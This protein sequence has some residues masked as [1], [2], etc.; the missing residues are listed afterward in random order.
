MKR[1]LR[2]VVSVIAFASLLWLVTGSCAQ[3]VCNNGSLKGTYA[4]SCTGTVG[5]TNSS[6]G[7]P[8]ADVGTV[9]FDGHGK[10]S[11]KDTYIVNGVQQGGNF[12][13]S[14]C[15]YT[16]KTD[17]TATLVGDPQPGGP[18]FDLALFD[19][20]YFSIETDPGTVVACVKH[21]Q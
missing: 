5:I 6:P 17:C 12:A 4:L 19:D 15:T 14:T 20:G 16:V 1:A 8:V 21:K 7:V 18:H 9:T 10:C 11:G 3:A 13:S 2:S